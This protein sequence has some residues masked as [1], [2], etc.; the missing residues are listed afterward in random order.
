MD[1][2]VILATPDITYR[3]KTNTQNRK[4]VKLEK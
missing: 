2:P 4:L 1:N 3:T